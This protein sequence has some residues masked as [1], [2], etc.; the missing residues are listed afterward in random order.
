MS[1]IK[2]TTLFVNVPGWIFP[3]SQCHCIT[4]HGA[5]KDLPSCEL[6]SVPS[7][8]RKSC[9]WEWMWADGCEN[10]K[11]KTIN[12]NHKM[13]ISNGNMLTTTN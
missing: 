7:K 8:K 10:C 9:Q 13:E 12:V 5:T 3:C 2:N 11:S 6:V 4:S 1:S